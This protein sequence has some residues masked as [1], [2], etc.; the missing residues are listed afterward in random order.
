MRRDPFQAV[1]DPIRREIIDLV[2]YKSLTVNELVENFDVSRQ[3]VSKHLK[4]L[5]ECGLVKVEKRGRERHCQAELDQLGE[6]ALWVHQY[7]QFWN[8][9]LDQLERLLTE[10]SKNDQDGKRR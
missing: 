9:R 1:A 6:I 7:R 8:N 4:I 10:E 5:R 3:A 2:S